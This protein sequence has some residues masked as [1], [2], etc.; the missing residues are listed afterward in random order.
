MVKAGVS[1]KPRIRPGRSGAGRVEAL[2]MFDQLVAGKK[3]WTAIG[4][5]GAPD[6]DR[7]TSGSG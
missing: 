6:D 4:F 2:A 3:N 1:E 5:D 7:Q